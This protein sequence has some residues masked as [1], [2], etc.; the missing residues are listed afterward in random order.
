MVLV[1]LKLLLL[2]YR[3]VSGCSLLIVFGFEL[4]FRW[5]S[6]TEPSSFW[7]QYAQTNRM[8]IVQ[9]SLYLYNTNAELA[10][11]ILH[12]PFLYQIVQYV[13][14]SAS[15]SN[16]VHQLT[17]NKNVIVSVRVKW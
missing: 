11:I 3:D 16:F 9:H 17:G 12:T 10:E 13:N 6:N 1:E 4:A 15:E 14:K 7:W 5:C 8:A 2:S